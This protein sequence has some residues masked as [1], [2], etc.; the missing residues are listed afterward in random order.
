MPGR[1]SGRSLSIVALPLLV[2][3]QTKTPVWAW[4][5]LGHVGPEARRCLPEREP[6]GLWRKRLYQASVRLA[7]V[8]NEAFLAP[9]GS[10]VTWMFHW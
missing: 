8:L 4:G 6:A 1:A 9:E 10:R 7:M 5:R 3:L 2:V